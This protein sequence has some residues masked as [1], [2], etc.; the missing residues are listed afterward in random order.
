MSYSEAI[1]KNDLKKILGNIGFGSLNDY[2][3]EQGTSGI[4]T[5]R[6]WKSGVAECWG[7]YSGSITSRT[8]NAPYNSSVFDIGVV[9]YPTD[10]FA[11]IPNVNVNTRIGSFYNLTSYANSYKDNVSI[12]ITSNVSGTQTVYAYIYAK[13]KWKS[14]IDTYQGI[15]SIGAVLLDT[16]HPVGSYYETSDASFDP[17]TAWGGTWVKVAGGLIKGEPLITRKQETPSADTTVSNS[18]GVNLVTVQHTSNTGKIWVYGAATIKTSNYTSA[19]NIDANGQMGFGT[20]TTN[21]KDFRRLTAMTQ[22]SGMPIGT[23]FT[24]ALRM[25]AQNT[26]TTATCAAYTTSQLFVSDVP[27]KMGYCWHRTA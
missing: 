15:G 9:N 12:S 19:I 21:M 2:I 6:K 16:F 22:R 11:D 13:G 3:I 4:W 20:V 23:P 7:I 10:F 14:D 5:Y 24:V 18:T 26:S 17:N 25:T 27:L 1:T 8:A